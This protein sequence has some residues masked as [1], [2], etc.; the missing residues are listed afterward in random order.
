MKEDGEEESVTVQQKGSIPAENFRE[1]ALVELREI[2][3][4]IVGLATDRDIYWKV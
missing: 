3:S 1:L 4:E 2:R